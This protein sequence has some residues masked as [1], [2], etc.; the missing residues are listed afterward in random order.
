MENMSNMTAIANILELGLQMST[1]L[2]VAMQDYN[3]LS[4]DFVDL[5]NTHHA[6]AQVCYRSFNAIKFLI[7]HHL[8]LLF[9]LYW[10]VFYINL[11]KH[12]LHNNNLLHIHFSYKLEHLSSHDSSSWLTTHC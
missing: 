6:H 2:L 1:G 8:H 3:L 7:A 11:T 4:V 12:T 9:A 5:E 10:I